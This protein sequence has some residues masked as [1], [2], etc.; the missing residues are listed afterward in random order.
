MIKPDWNI[1]KAKFSENPQNNFEWLVYSLFCREFNLKTGIF[2]FKNQRGIETEP[3]QYDEEYIGWQAKFY[4]TSL[5][6]H[7]ADFIK[8]LDNTKISHQNITKL[9]VFT[10][11]E[12]GQSKGQEPKTKID[13]DNHAKKK[14]IKLEWRCASY[15]ETPDVISK[16]LDLYRH[17]FSLSQSVYEKLEL[18]HKHS[19]RLMSRISSSIEFDDQKITI[20]RTSIKDS[21]LQSF[22][23]VVLLTGNGGVGKTAIIKQIYEENKESNH[24]YYVH[25]AS[26]FNVSKVTNFLYEIDLDDFI[27]IHENLSNKVII[28]DSAESL[29]TITNLEPF[30]EY[31]EA[32]LAADWKIWFTTRD[33]YKNDFS[34][35][36]V[37][38]YRVLYEDIS[39][40]LLS[41]AQLNEIASKYRIELPQDDKL[42]DLLRNLF[43]FKEYLRFYEKNIHLDYN[44]FRDSL[45]PQV[46]SKNNPRR[47]TLFIEIAKKRADTGSFFVNIGAEPVDQNLLGELIEDGILVNDQ[48]H[49]YIAHDIYEEWG[50]NQYIDVQYQLHDEEKDFFD[51]IGESLP[52]RRAFRKWLSEKLVEE[53]YDFI[54]F[55]KHCFNS[56]NVSIIWL[57]ELIT[58]I[59]LSENSKFFF[60]SYKDHILKNDDQIFSKICSFLKMSCKQLD[61][62]I[63]GEFSLSSFSV[64]ELNYLFTKPKG[65]GWIQFIDF[66]STHFSKIEESQFTTIVP[67]LQEW[68]KTNKSGK[69]TKQAGLIAKKIFEN[70][71][72]AK[73]NSKI[74]DDLIFIIVSSVA[75]NKN[76]VSELIDL[77]IKNKVKKHSNPYIK[78]IEYILIKMEGWICATHIPEKVRELAEEVWFIEE[79]SRTN[80]LNNSSIRNHWKYGMSS[81]NY[82]Y[83]PV[84]AFQT[85]AYALLKSNFL[86]TLK[87]ILKIVNKAVNQ[88][89]KYVHEYETIT[90]NID[91]RE[92]VQYINSTLWLIY[93]GN[94]NCPDILTSVHMALEK[95]LLE[96]CKKTNEEQ[97]THILKV[98]L[99][100]TQSAS[101]TAVVASVAMAYYEKCFDII[102]ILI[103]NK[104]ILLND[105]TRF[106][107]EK[108]VQFGSFRR[109]DYLQELHDK[110][111][112]E[113]NK[114][115]HRNCTLDHVVRCF[116]FFRNESVSEEVS[117]SRLQDLYLIIDN[118]Y[119][120]LEEI[121]SDDFEAK[122]W[123]IFLS[124]MDRRLLQTD[125]KEQDGQLVIEFNPQF[126]D[127][128]KQFRTENL[129]DLNERTK[130]VSVELWIRYK[131]D[132]DEKCKKF[133]SYETNPLAALFEV[134]PI[135]EALKKGSLSD[136]LSLYRALPA[137]ISVVLIRE[138]VE[139][140]DEKSLALC[141][142]ILL[143]YCSE[144]FLPD[145]YYGVGTGVV[146]AINILPKLLY[147]KTDKYPQIKSLIVVI[148]LKPFQINIGGNLSSNELIGSI[149]KFLA[150]N[151]EDILSIYKGYLYLERKR[152]ID[153]RK[154][155]RY[156]LKDIFQQF[157][158]E[159]FFHEFLKKNEPVFHQIVSN[160]INS[161]EIDKLEEYE[162]VSLVSAFSFS[163][164]NNHS[165]FQ[166]PY[167]EKIINI[168][169]TSILNDDRHDYETRS[170]SKSRFFC[171]YATYVLESKRTEDIERLITPILLD[172]NI[173]ESLS[174]LINEFVLV[175]DR[176]NK[177]DNF[178]I[179]WNLLKDKV[180]N[181]YKNYGFRYDSEKIISSYMLANT[182][183]KQEAK[184]WPALGVDKKFFFDELTSELGSSCKYL[185]NLI[186]LVTG[187]GEIYQ[188]DSIYWLARSIKENED[189]I[190]KHRDFKGLIDRLENLLRKFCL[191]NRDKIKSTVRLKKAVT[192][193]LNFLVSQESVTG[194]MLRDDMV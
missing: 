58:S 25:K 29:L 18:F 40:P 101:I 3:T 13:I 71:V 152:Q 171:D 31:L 186:D 21:L 69:A 164:W 141:E 162:K 64:E 6:S 38:S 88:Y 10:N 35:L 42:K 67:I 104:I 134:T 116:S 30:H 118:Y 158:Y 170:Y 55:I 23:Q 105:E 5:S 129:K 47:A 109:N 133:E 135:W 16:N 123:R 28:I 155:Q 73:S 84:S 100:Q 113:S 132:H 131:L 86:D 54:D 176:L 177:N 80:H 78:L 140:L 192:S 150:S 144:M 173:S 169:F 182:R 2:R 22:S 81:D 161:I 180:L 57:D 79:S 191:R 89:I 59:L 168:I 36:L 24:V 174:D 160:E 77:A 193:L 97:T 122:T 138:Y 157:D 11:A 108:T 87:F 95:Y 83:Y 156:E 56:N 125:V 167:T 117:A 7:K 146:E 111:R 37:Q 179:V 102:K 33:Q 107:N 45:W 187:I 74:T 119:A 143:H 26:E 148:L 32:L 46:I 163:L 183:W 60:N 27:K 159:G 50:L 130:Y 121:E 62:K 49:Y 51:S 43:Y 15:F 63:L 66:V 139:L 39:V 127:D 153:F 188:E 53:S 93:R 194:Y 98:I 14:N 96:I 106:R 70:K 44:K 103:S 90:L 175:Q 172:L 136:Y 128:L 149:H 178:W 4:D 20:D 124:K 114:L 137:L 82:D 166:V 72:E 12:W 189:K 94:Q 19:N 75:E 185:N 41:F 154:F 181:I 1:F 110:E 52:I 85:P 61:Q 92:V 68:N 165:K 8:M 34:F 91:G 126:S 99:L 145:F 190:V 48:S 120:D 147:L 115:P 9:I 142:E 184:S 112:E 65:D 151:Y 17:F 76:E